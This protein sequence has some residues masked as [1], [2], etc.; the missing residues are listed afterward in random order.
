MAVSGIDELSARGL[1][2]MVARRRRSGQTRKPG[3]E[4]TGFCRRGREADALLA[5]CR[6]SRIKARAETGSLPTTAVL[7]A[8]PPFNPARRGRQGR[9]PGPGRLAET[10]GVTALPM[11]EART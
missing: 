6:R 4:T 5:L 9:R 1:C 8:V 10:D 2:G 7:P 3:E 11:P